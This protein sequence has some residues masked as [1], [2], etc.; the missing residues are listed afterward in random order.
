MLNAKSDNLTTT[1][2][3]EELEKQVRGFA[4]ILAKFIS[5]YYRARG[6][7]PPN[8]NLVLQIPD[9]KEY[10]E[11]EEVEIPTAE[12][13][14]LDFLTER[15]AEIGSLLS[16][17]EKA[18][19]STF[20]DIG[21]QPHAV[22]EAKKLVMAIKHSE[23]FSK[24]GVQR[25]RGILLVGP[26][27][28]GKTML[29]KAIAREAGADFI[30]LSVT[31]LVSKWYGEAEQKVQ[32]FFDGA[33]T[34]SD[35]GKDVIVFI[36]E[37][38]SVVPPRGES[39]E[40]TQKMTAVFLQNMD[41][42]K[43]NPRLT[44]LAASNRPERIDEAFLRPG[45]LD[46]R[47]RLDLPDVDGR[48]Q[49]LEIQ[50]KRHLA[51]ASDSENLISPDLDTRDVAQKL[52]GASGADIANMVNLALEEK[53]IAEIKYEEGLPDGKPWTPLSADDILAAREKYMP[54]PKVKPQ[55]GFRQT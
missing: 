15:K 33:K 35:K 43:S 32:Q 52:E 9:W 25:P 22:E 10:G 45:R 14:P 1:K 55:I 20:A 24:R 39:H 5:V 28:V 41:G 23:V 49:I 16:E 19:M 6:Y 54:S 34:I 31:D 44:I 4:G 8:Q 48:A 40:A 46:K 38:D 18:I 29:A 27:G 42:L 36:D 3:P 53:T 12:S 13:S 17:E 47:I 30:S 26:P 37:I 51:A 7:L 2:K 50:L 21:G 11:T